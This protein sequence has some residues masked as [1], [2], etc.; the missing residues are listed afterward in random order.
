MDTKLKSLK[1]DFILKSE[2]LENARIELKK[3]FVGLDAIID[4]IIEVVSTWYTLNVIQDKPLIVN[5]W[6][7]TGTGKTALVNR[8]TELL[9]IE[10]SYYRFDLGEKTGFNSFQ[11]KIS[12]LC[13]NKED[14]P[15]IIALDE[16]QHART[17]KG[18][19]REELENDVNRKVWDLIDSGKVN[20]FSWNGSLWTLES[21][22][23]KMNYQLRLGKIDVQKGEVT[24]NPEQFCK[25]MGYTFDQKEPTL[26]VPE[27]LYEDIL[28]II[29][30]ELKI[31]LESELKTFLLSLN[32]EK[33]IQFLE[34]VIKLG[35]RPSIKHFTKSLVFVL[36]NI[37]EAYTMSGDFSA[38]IDADEFHKQSLKIKIPKIKA[39]LRS[40]F[41]DE[42]IARLGNIHLIYP[43]LNKV[44]YMRII[45]MEI[46]KTLATLNQ[47]LN[48]AC[49]FDESLMQT[50]YE[51]GVYPVQGVRPVFTTIQHLLKSKL[52]YFVM[53]LIKSEDTISNMHFSVHTDELIC[54][55]QH[56]ENTI[57]IQSSKL[58]LNLRKLRKNRKDELQT[59]VAVHESGHTVLYGA[60]M[61][62]IPE[63]VYSVTSD[64][65]TNGFVY[66]NLDRKIFAK[67]DLLPYAACLLGGIVAEELVF[68]EQHKTTGSSSDIEKVTDF[69]ISKLKTQGFG[70]QTIRFA[71]F[72]HHDADYF[73]AIDDIEKQAFEIVKEAKALALETLNKEKELLLVLANF[74]SNNSSIEKNQL[75]SMFNTYAKT[76]ID[77]KEPSFYRDKLNQE[78]VK[79]LGKQSEIEN[80]TNLLPFQLNKGNKND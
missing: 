62:K 46:Q 74:L 12:D 71:N 14:S 55:Y 26:F 16:F 3:E 30:N 27:S 65:E 17:V 67:K 32:G 42:Q 47:N 43:A 31:K 25:E 70:D 58:A 73:H 54:H 48:I 57:F 49:S 22:I 44:A 24:L 77:S 4:E 20:F 34:K 64:N 19:F 66:A 51:E 10:N 79:I 72:N 38:D 1:Q 60:L 52:S 2:I 13:E 39:V 78:M 23:N 36:G 50:I 75:A 45:E 29:G 8:L 35:Q 6:G 11:N 59:V 15:I 68:G 63:N 61:N 76:K 37:D 33:T 69:V 28:E 56:N 80:L 7:L 18:S 21:N 5:L 40:R 53:H 9:Q 41:R